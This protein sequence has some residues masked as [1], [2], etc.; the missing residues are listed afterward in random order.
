MARST[1]NASLREDLGGALDMAEA[2]LIARQARIRNKQRRKVRPTHEG[3]DNSK[4]KVPVE[5][6]EAA[7]DELLPQRAAVAMYKEEWIAARDAL[8]DRLYELFHQ[9]YPAKTLANAMFGRKE[10]SLSNVTSRVERRRQQGNA[11]KAINDT[12]AGPDNP[13]VT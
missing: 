6:V 9:G 11:R 2:R 13:F 1:D 5:A 8:D 10:N 12:L 7:I 4:L 3:M